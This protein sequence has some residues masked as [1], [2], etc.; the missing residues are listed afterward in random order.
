MEPT[1]LGPLKFF[2]ESKTC[3]LNRHIV[4]VGGRRVAAAAAARRAA[5]LPWQL[6]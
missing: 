2:S 1:K 6:T 4:Y 5:S 3:L